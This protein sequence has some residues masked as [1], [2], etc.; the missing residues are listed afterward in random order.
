MCS[1]WEVFEKST[2]RGTFI[3]HLKVDISVY[4]HY[5]Q[6]RHCHADMIFAVNSIEFANEFY[7]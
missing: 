7:F 3:R 6:V 2:E 1:G 5:R 4:P